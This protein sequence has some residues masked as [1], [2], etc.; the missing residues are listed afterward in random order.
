MCSKP[1][2]WNA[3]QLIDAIEICNHADINYKNSKN[4]RLTVEIALMQLSSLTTS[5][6]VSKKKSS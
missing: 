1:R 3:Q 2:N 5:Q 6:D 4:P